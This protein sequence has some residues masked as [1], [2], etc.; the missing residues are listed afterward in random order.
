MRDK[1]AAT[2]RARHPGLTSDPAPVRR[3][4]GRHGGQRVERAAQ[5][6][7]RG[8]P[9]LHHQPR[10]RERLRPA[11]PP[12]ACVQPSTLE[13]RARRGLRHAADRGGRVGL[14]QRHLSHARDAPAQPHRADRRRDRPRELRLRRRRSVHLL[15][16]VPAAAVRRRRDLARAGRGDADLRR[17]PRA[18]HGREAALAAAD[19]RRRR[20]R[21]ISAFREESRGRASH[22][23]S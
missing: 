1:L 5:R 18:P 12:R 19:L 8:L 23:R 17:E 16:P 14:P 3:C 7:R 4:A 20:G 10:R 21:P 9:G 6:R 13:Q 11:A 22:R 15:R 2:R